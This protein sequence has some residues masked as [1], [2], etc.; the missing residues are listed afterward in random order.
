[1]YEAFYAVLLRYFYTRDRAG[2]EA[3]E[4]AI[5]ALDSWDLADPAELVTWLLSLAPVLRR[6][7]RQFPLGTVKYAVVTLQGF[8]NRAR[9][10]RKLSHGRGGAYGAGLA[11]ALEA[12][13]QNPALPL[14]RQRFV[15]ADGHPRHELVVPPLSDR[16]RHEIDRHVKKNTPP[17]EFAIWLVAQRL[18]ISHEGGVQKYLNALARLRRSTRSSRTT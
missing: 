8:L 11:R 12:W 2:A 13:W 9:T 10:G 1:M 7:G 4:D 18:R 17:R 15:G 6:K 5:C 16:I 3:F 14:V